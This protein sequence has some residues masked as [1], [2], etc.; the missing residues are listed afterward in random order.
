M[1]EAAEGG[2]GRGHARVLR[3]AAVVT[4]LLVVMGGTVCVT[5]ST[6][7]CPDWPACYGRLVPPAR[8][9]SII[10]YT[11]RF[12]AL[13]AGPLVLA[14]AALGLWR[15]RGAHWISRAPILAVALFA[16]VAVFGAFAVL[17]GLPPILAAVDL[18]SALMALALLLAAAE[19]ARLANAR[20]VRPG[21]LRIAGPVGTAAAATAVAVFFVLVLG[22]LVAEPG[23]I[24]R[25]LGWP[26]YAGG[27]AV[28][29]TRAGL[30][31]PVRLGLSGLA[32]AG[33]VLLPVL[34]W[35]A[36]P[37]HRGAAWKATAAAGLLALELLLGLRLAAGGAGSAWLVTYVALAAAIWTQLIV[38]LV[39]LALPQRSGA[40]AEARSAEA[41]AGGQ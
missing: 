11:H 13:L 10:E 25:C 12:L 14:A 8:A 37:E 23:S 31:Q 41:P 30:L 2:I 18:G 35:R 15:A 5:G 33:V 6:L 16:A 40:A 17:T 39:D 19:T 26:L 21:G 22:V 34:A 20:G 32:V 27:E 7:G 29:A 38:L 28:A 36:G 3:A 24:V 4:F 1:S 9:D